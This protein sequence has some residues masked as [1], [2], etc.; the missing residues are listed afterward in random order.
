MNRRI[1]MLYELEQG[2]T[3]RV[4]DIF[5][6]GDMRR[7]FMDMGLIRGTKVSCLIKSAGGHISA[8]LVRGTVIAVRSDDVREIFV[9]KLRE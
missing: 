1:Y 2:E 9:E 8:Y 5:T 7:R 6:T 4:T 3:G